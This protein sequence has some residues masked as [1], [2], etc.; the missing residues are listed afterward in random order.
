MVVDLLFTYSAQLSIVTDALL[1]TECH[2]QGCG[3]GTSRKLLGETDD[4]IALKP[5]IKYKKTASF[6]KYI[7]VHYVMKKHYRQF[8]VFI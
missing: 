2:L 7:L 6:H 8:S 5:R 4:Q 3:D 1:G